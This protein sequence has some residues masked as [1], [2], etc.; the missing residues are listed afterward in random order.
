MVTIE[1]LLISGSP[2]HKFIPFASLPAN[3]SY[4][5]L[6]IFI[7]TNELP[8]GIA[9][10]CMVNCNCILGGWPMDKKSFVIIIFSLLLV[11]FIS[12]HIV[13]ACAGDDLTGI[14]DGSCSVMMHFKSMVILITYNLRLLSLFP[15]YVTALTSPTK[16]M[17]VPTGPAT[18]EAGRPSRHKGRP[19]VQA[20][21]YRRKRAASLCRPPYV[22]SQ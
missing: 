18:N 9:I 22:L 16:A 13:S 15:P 21:S 1:Y 20:R 7:P 6:Y 4:T 2:L 14:V 5:Q 11:I 3:I 10:H 19:N 17:I 12:Y 8:L